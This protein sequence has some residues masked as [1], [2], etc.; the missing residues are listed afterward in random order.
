MCFARVC[1]IY[2]GITGEGLSMKAF[3]SVLVLC[4]VSLYAYGLD[5]DAFDLLNPP[6][7]GGTG[8]HNLGSTAS[9]SLLS[10]SGGTWGTGAY[11]GS[12]DFVLHPKVTALVDLGYARTFDFSGGD[13]F[14]HVLGGLQLEWK[15]TGSTS[16]TLQYRGAVPTG[17]DEGF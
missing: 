12:M 1:V 16:F 13:R 17:R 2:K 11:I 5:A 8:F 9:F 14:G 3:V 10:G 15:P 4:S 7:A 6:S